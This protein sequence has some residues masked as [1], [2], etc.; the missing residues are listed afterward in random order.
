MVSSVRNPLAHEIH[1]ELSISGLYT[2][3]DCLDALGLLSH[4]SRRLDDALE[5]KNDAEKK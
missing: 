4:L 2:E 5:V 3:K 1:K